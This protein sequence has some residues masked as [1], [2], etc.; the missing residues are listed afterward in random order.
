MR[1][2]ILITLV[3]LAG[4]SQPVKEHPILYPVNGT[5]TLKGKLLETGIVNITP[6]IDIPNIILNG[7]ILK[8][9][10]FKIICNL[11][12]V[13]AEGAPTGKYRATILAGY[14]GNNPILYPSTKVLEVKT[15]A[16]IWKLDASVAQ[17][18]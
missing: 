17:K 9:G 5:A 14:T 2:I 10:S 4:C 13:K 18:Q 7:Q 1:L 16:N 11:E 6:E 15:S 8:D 3:N 12:G